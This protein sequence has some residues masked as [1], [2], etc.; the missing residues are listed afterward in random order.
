MTDCNKC[1][2]YDLKKD[3]C[4]RDKYKCECG[5]VRIKAIIIDTRPT[6]TC[7]K[8]GE[9]K[10]NDFN[11]FGKKWGGTRTH[12]IT[13]DVCKVCS[14]KAISAGHMNNWQHRGL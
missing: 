2:H 4:N 12:Y 3:V 7:R 8:C 14:G 10:S 6:K 5:K 1:V 13:V 9:L 11:N